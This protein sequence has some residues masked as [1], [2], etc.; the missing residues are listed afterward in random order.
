M[1]E[2]F[3]TIHQKKIV[4]AMS[5]GVDSSV[6]AA[7]LQ[8]QGARVQGVFMALAQPDL[9]EQLRWVRSVADFLKI[10]LT[11]VDLAEPFRRE[12]VD[13][14]CASYF[15]GKTPNP[16]MVCNRAIKF[17]RL[18]DEAGKSLGAELLATGHYART[19]GD[20]A[21]GYRLLKGVDPKKDQ[22]YFLGL[23]TQ[24]Q[25]GRLCFPLGS[26]RK[27]EVYELA[28][29]FGLTFRQTA[30]SQ[31]VCF[32]KAEL[33][34]LPAHTKLIPSGCKAELGS[35]P[36]HTKFIPSGCKNQPVVE[37]LAAHSPGQAR[38]G[39]MLTLQGR[40]LGRHGGI[41]QYTVGQRRG[42]GLP[43]AT[44]WYVA[45]LDLKQNA[46]LLGKEADLW[47]QEALLPEVHWQSGRPPALPRVCE[48]KIRSRQPVCLAEIAGHASGGVRLTFSEPQRAV[49]PGQ[50]AVFYEGEVVLGCGEIAR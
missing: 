39:P 25:L 5:G 38:P 36:A 40:E 21:T 43:D 29:E 16:C 33:S 41:H 31:D 49:T 15:A 7:L 11:V 32:L 34:S 30:E 27:Q 44:P 6:T 12:V 28:A 13:Y 18:L 17:G 48:V 20:R 1:E 10:P 47:Q 19:S 9:A 22:S 46:V 2:R 26:F 24:A 3:A 35:L 45:G 50:F 14:F 8:R 42:L 4:V 37:F 23:L